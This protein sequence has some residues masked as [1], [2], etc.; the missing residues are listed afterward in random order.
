MGFKEG[1]RDMTPEEILFLDSTGLKD[2]PKLLDDVQVSANHILMLSRHTL[3]R[4]WV[5]AELCAARKEKKN[6]CV[7]LV[8][9]PGKDN[10]SKQFRFPLDLETA[11]TEWKD[12]TISEHEQ[13]MKKHRRRS[14]VGIKVVG[15]MV[16]KRTPSD[17]KK[18]DIKKGGDMYS[19]ARRTLVRTSTIFCSRAKH[20]THLEMRRSKSKRPSLHQVE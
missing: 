17:T 9:Y 19:P 20:L 5:L 3:E 2:L 11:I 4:P 1:V 12:Y 18:R 8:E 13:A 14:M 10:N 15:K 16:G 7:V 6:I